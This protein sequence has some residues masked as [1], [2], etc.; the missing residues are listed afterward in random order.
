MGSL[1]V[2]ARD[3]D[4]NVKADILHER[5]AVDGVVQVFKKVAVGKLIALEALE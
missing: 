1:E 3:K 2:I 4:G 5:K